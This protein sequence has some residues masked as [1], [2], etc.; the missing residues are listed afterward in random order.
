[1][2]KQ[3]LILFTVV[4]A[5]LL[6]APV[7]AQHAGHG[8][9]QLA[10]SAAFAPD[11]TLWLVGVE[12]GK[13]F[14]QRRLSGSTWDA[15]RVLDH[16]DDVVATNG[17]NRPKLAFGPSGQ[18]A[19]SYTRPLSK[20]YTG[21]IRMLRSDDDGTSFSAP[22][23]V[24]QDRQIITHR[25]DSILFDARGDLYTFWIDKRDAERAWAAANGDLAVY[26]GAAIYYNVSTDGGKSFGPDTR[27]ADYSCECCRIA[28]AA[29]PA[30]GVALM[31]R[32][33]FPG[34]VRDHAFAI[35]GN[36]QQGEVV[37]SSV[38]QWVLKAC[39]HHGPG[40]ARDAK[41]G[42]HTV[43]FG[44]KA[45]RQRVRYGRL[46]A[47]G[48]PQGKPLELPDE[49]AEHADLAVVGR[50]VVI[51]WRSFD[52]QRTRLRAWISHDGGRRFTLRELGASELQNDH[53]RLAAHDGS[54]A[55]VWRTENDVQVH[56]LR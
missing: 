45:G 2:V 56:D 5:L 21:E 32:H 51:A 48:R 25:F 7:S 46:D 23:T 30:G 11:G 8:K 53:P 33:I 52:G 27:L 37:R 42:Y 35:V 39:P 55:V 16:G 28:V 17:D 12:H 1:M 43:W 6:G 44:D 40:L 24:H 49:R 18:V 41:G 13:L 9:P 4:A 20:P 14:V 15:R 36:G 3:W 31:W 54:I 34:S 38:D 19:I 29:E 10:S 22:F 50:T 47:S 26:P